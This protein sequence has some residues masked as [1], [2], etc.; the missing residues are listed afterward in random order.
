MIRDRGMAACKV[1][2]RKRGLNSFTMTKTIYLIVIATVSGAFHL[3]CAQDSTK[4]S[5][6][7]AVGIVQTT[8]PLKQVLHPAIAFSSEIEYITKKKWFADLTFDLASLK[9]NQQVKDSVSPYLFQNARSSLFMVGLNGGKRLGLKN[10]NSSVSLY[11]GGGYLTIGEPRA[12]TTPDNIIRQ[13][14]VRKSAF[15]GRLGTRAEYTTKIKILQGIYLDASWWISTAS[16][17]D[18]TLHGFAVYIGTRVQIL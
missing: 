16:V 17:Q 8:G 7:T 12:N 11:G 10:K 5:Y 4:V 6:G 15:Y 18:L 2:R 13:T 9:Y 1:T 3:A 14:I